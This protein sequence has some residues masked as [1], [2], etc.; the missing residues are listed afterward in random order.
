VITHLEVCES[1]WEFFCPSKSLKFRKVT[2]LPLSSRPKRSEV[3]GSAVRLAQT[4][5]LFSFFGAFQV[6]LVGETER[7]PRG[8][9]VGPGQ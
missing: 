4:L 8:R 3:E 6:R 9:V 7:V 1:D 2:A 5:L